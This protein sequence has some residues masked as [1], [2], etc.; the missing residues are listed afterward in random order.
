MTE[1]SFG[2]IATIGF[3]CAFVCAVVA[4]VMFFVLHIREVRD[5]LTGASAR[6]SIA[7][8]REGRRGVLRVGDVTVSGGTAVAARAAGVASGSLHVRMADGAA[9]PVED[10]PA[11]ARTEVPFNETP[12]AGEHADGE[13][14]TTLL[15]QKSD[16]ETKAA[17]PER[18]AEKQQVKDC[19]TT[20]LSKPVDVPRAQSEDVPGDT[21]PAAAEEGCTT[22]LS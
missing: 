15:S 1:E 18:L 2:L 20:L 7:Q 12:L 10:E 16:V 6:R 21:A 14:L 13:R 11:P 5:E 22:L 19:E 3:T 4:I 9:K 17:S 8:M